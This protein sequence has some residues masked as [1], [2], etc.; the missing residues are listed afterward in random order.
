MVEA[1]SATQGTSGAYQANFAAMQQML[2]QQMFQSADTSGNGTISK[3]EFEK[4]YN[5]FMGAN[6]TP[7]SPSSTT[8]AADQLYQQ[9]NTTGNGLTL[10]QFTTAV[11]LMMSQKAQGQR[12]LHGVG[13][14]GTGST[15][16][17]TLLQQ[18]LAAGNQN[19]TAQ[20]APAQTGGI[21]FIA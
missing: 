9:L 12:H 21:E 17:T 2:I 11:K 16:P 13:A 20:S 10:G 18:M 1:I 7:G 15:N 6:S 3:S 8:A 19:T 5:Q 14:A 4:F